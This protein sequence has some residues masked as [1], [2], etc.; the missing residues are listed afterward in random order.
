MGAAPHQNCQTPK[1]PGKEDKIASGRV[2][3]S[4][5]IALATGRNWKN[6]R[7]H[8]LH[9]V[10]LTRLRSQIENQFELSLFPKNV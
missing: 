9:R 10:R 5:A 8:H 6:P 3:H 4:A 2:G 7:I 1:G